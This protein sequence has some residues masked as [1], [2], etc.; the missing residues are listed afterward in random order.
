MAFLVSKD[1]FSDK[2]NSDYTIE[3]E[4]LRTPGKGVY[5]RKSGQLLLL[6][7]KDATC[8]KLVPL[9]SHLDNYQMYLLKDVECEYTSTES[10]KKLKFEP[11]K[12]AELGKNA[13]E[14]NAINEFNSKRA[15]WNAYNSKTSEWEKIQPKPIRSVKFKALLTEIR[16]H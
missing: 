5:D 16:D 9:V 6:I 1:A 12:I 4:A 14:V 7:C 2:T 10:P 3:P 8:Q 15:G 11:S 13:D